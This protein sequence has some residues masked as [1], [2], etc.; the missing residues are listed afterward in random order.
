M[1]KHLP[2]A[3]VLV[4]LALVGGATAWLAFRQAGSDRGPAG[5][6]GSEPPAAA[7]EVSPVESGTVRDVRRLTGT[8]ESSAR[9]VVATK[10]GGLVQRVLVDLGDRVEQGQVI[11]RIDDTELVQAVVQ[12]EADLAVRRAERTRAHSELDLARREFDRGEQLRER[13]IAADAQLDEIAAR[14]RS[15]EAAFALAEAQVNRA[16]SALELRRIELGYTQVRANWSEDAAAG[17]I[18][19]RY[20][21]PGNLVQANTPVVSVVALDPLKAVVFVTERDYAGLAPGQPATITTDAAPGRTFPATIERIAPVFRETSR[22]ARI[23]LAVPNPDGVLR[24]GMFARVSIVLGEQR[25]DTV[26]PRSALSRRNGREVVFVVDEGSEVA[27][28][29]EVT[30]GIA[31][32]DR[33]TI[34]AP[35]ISGRVVT[36]GQQ[37]LDDGA[38]VRIARELGGDAGAAP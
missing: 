37:L 16:E 35:A 7:V 22:Q 1:K 14:L 6:T 2:T 38:R 27:R 25:S 17:S 28:M 24:P 36:L 31:E 15:S 8:L 19:E 23:E 4:V 29:V 32:G 26:I 12:A 5:P 3:V 20:Q 10:V 11:A 34:V 18:A 21:D 13:G 33:V 9:F 30:T